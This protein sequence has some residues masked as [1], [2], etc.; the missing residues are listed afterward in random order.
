MVTI[1][2][3]LLV[4]IA[5]FMLYFINSFKIFYV[6][7]IFNR[8]LRDPLNNPGLVFKYIMKRR[9]IRLDDNV[10]LT[11][12]LYENVH[13]SLKVNKTLKKIISL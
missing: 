7:L 6:F 1:A 5:L 12:G 10:K 13:P 9:K 4:T 8:K 3:I 2:V 11:M